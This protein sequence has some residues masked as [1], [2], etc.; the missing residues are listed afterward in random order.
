MGAKRKYSGREN[1]N[2]LFG[3]AGLVFAIGFVVSAFFWNVV[4]DRGLQIT[5]SVISLLGILISEIA[6]RQ[7]TRPV[8]ENGER[9]QG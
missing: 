6:R 9:H 5:G 2:D 7:V 4:G 3:V 8:T 1:L